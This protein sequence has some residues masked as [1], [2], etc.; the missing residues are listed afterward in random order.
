MSNELALLRRIE[1][2]EKQIFDKRPEI[3]KPYLE[4]LKTPAIP[5]LMNPVTAKP[6]YD[7]TNLGFLFD[8]STAE[9]V[10]IIQQMP[11]NWVAGTIIYPHVHWSPT[12]THTGSV[13]WVM[14]Y[15]WTNENDADAGG[16][17]IGGLQAGSG[18]A[19]THQRVA[20][21]TGIDG[22]G[23]TSSSILSIILQ[24]S[25]AHASDTYT[26][27]ALLKVFDIHAWLDPSKSYW[28]P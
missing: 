9:Y 24:R 6:D 7:Y 16:T 15:K 1:A 10:Y 23:K 5:G 20:I 25:A 27:D 11:H 22:T 12:T 28:V 14:T 17:S 18:T 19:Y 8:A 4:D 13:Y 21:G 26:G 3:G 2:L